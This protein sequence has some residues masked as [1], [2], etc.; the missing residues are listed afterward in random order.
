MSSL[1]QSQGSMVIFR[2]RDLPTCWQLVISYRMRAVID[3][4]VYC[5]VELSFC[6]F[7]EMKLL[8]LGTLGL[9]SEMAPLVSHPICHAARSVSAEVICC[10]TQSWDVMLTIS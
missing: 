8:G 9:G 1:S 6:Q 5:R 3:T 4:A 7:I 10:R 2:R